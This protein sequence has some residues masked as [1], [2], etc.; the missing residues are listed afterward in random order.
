QF[1]LPFGS[2]VV[3]F[4]GKAAEDPLGTLPAGI[5]GGLLMTIFEDIAISFGRGS[6]EDA[7]RLTREIESEGR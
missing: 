4:G 6:A 7:E 2:S 3:R 1:A 5:A